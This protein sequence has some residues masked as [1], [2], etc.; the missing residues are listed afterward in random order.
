MGGGSE[1][2]GEGS[3]MVMVCERQK[4]RGSEKQR[5]LLLLE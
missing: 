3:I 2:K 5:R 4:V 1:G